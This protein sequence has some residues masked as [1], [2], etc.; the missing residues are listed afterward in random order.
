MHKLARIAYNGFNWNRPSGDARKYEAPDT[1]NAVNGFGYEEWL[2][3]HE[4]LLDGWRYSF[5]QGF[6][7]S[8]E[9]LTADPV[10][11]DL[12]LYTIEPDNRRRF[13][14]TIT[15]VECLP[16][17]HAV[18]ALQ[19]FKDQGWYDQMRA[20]VLEVGGNATSFG[21]PDWARH[22]LNLRYRVENVAL[23]PSKT[24]LRP[25][26]RIMKLPRYSLYDVVELDHHSNE[27]RIPKRAGA[28][29]LPDV[30][31]YWREGHGKTQCTP[32]HAK[33]QA[34]LMELLR[35]KY[36]T[37]EIKRENDFIDV[38][39]QTATELLLF[40]IKSDLTA[41]AVI[42]CALGQILEYAFHP[43]RKHDAPLRLIIVGRSG[44]SAADAEYLAILQ[45]EFRLPIDYL[46]V[47]V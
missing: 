37:A 21:S 33:I 35:A 44:L 23:F 38:T 6:N 7:K 25:D 20:E 34:K 15:G 19:A 30:R 1:H 28:T 41:T 27:S 17:L 26:D 43:K 45:R 3:R 4:W 13:V 8:Y 40:E 9:V 47:E 32:E 14:A 10:P 5:V 12:T 2:F 39:V 42:R 16:E 36:P 31:P 29:D 24:Y 18:D 11:I 22:V 46:M